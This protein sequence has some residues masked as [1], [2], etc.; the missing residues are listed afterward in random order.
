MDGTLTE[1]NNGFTTAR[2]IPLP[3]DATGG[4]IRS[5]RYVIENDG[6]TWTCETS[7]LV[8]GDVQ[9]DSG[10]CTGVGDYEGIRAYLVIDGNDVAGY[11]TSGDGPPLPEV[12]AE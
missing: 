8:V 11:I 7:S 4:T 3:A 12:S 6:G 2:G 10:W 5:I 1:T 9:G